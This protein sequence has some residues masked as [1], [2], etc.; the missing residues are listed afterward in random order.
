MA[1]ELLDPAVPE[2]HFTLHFLVKSFSQ[3]SSFLK[4]AWVGVLLRVLVIQWCLTLCDPMDYSL[5]GSSVHG[6]FQARILEWVAMPSSR[7]SSQ[8]RDRTHD[9][10][11][12]RI[13]RQV[14]YHQCYLGSPSASLPDL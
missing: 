12:S 3:L 14:L 7:G 9:S 10:Y 1:F 8:P 13:G 2:G 6:I 4:C 5:P 11:V